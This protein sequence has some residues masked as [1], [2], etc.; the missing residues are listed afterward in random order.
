MSKR[1]QVRIFVVSMDDN[2]QQTDKL[3][4]RRVKNIISWSNRLTIAFLV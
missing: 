1:I 3:Q 2:K 4:Y